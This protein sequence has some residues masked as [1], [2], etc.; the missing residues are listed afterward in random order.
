MADQ[1]HTAPNV[2]D[3]R[4]KTPTRTEGLRPGFAILRLGFAIVRLGLM[5]SAA[6][7]IARLA[8]AEIDFN[9][10]TISSVRQ[11]AQIGNSEYWMRLAELDPPHAPHFLREAALVDPRDAAAWIAL[12]LAEERV[13]EESAAENRKS[14]N[15]KSPKRTSPNDRSKSGDFAAAR[16]A[17]DKAFS[18][19]RQYSP[20]WAL[21]NF[22]LR[23]QDQGPDYDACFWRAAAR[24]ALRSPSLADLAIADSGGN[25]TGSSANLTD[26][27][28]LLDLAGRMEPSP[29]KTLDRLAASINQFAAADG[30][31]ATYA[32][33]IGRELE[34]AWL[35]DLIGQE[36]WEDAALI[37]QR[38]ESRHDAADK[39]RLDDLVDRL[40]AAGKAP[41]AVA[42]WNGYAA[43]TAASGNGTSAALAPFNGASLTNGDFA[44]EPTDMGFDW[45]LGLHPAGAFGSVLS[46][47]LGNDARQI[48]KRWQPNMLEFRLS[49]EEP[50]QIPMSEQWLPLAR[51]TYK[52][53]FEYSTRGLAAPT[54][55]RWDFVTRAGNEDKENQAAEKERRAGN[56]SLA[57]SE[58]WR[59]GE[60]IFSNTV[61]GVS[62]NTLPGVSSQR[63]AR[64]LTLGR[65][66]LIYSR[67]PGTERA[68]GLFSLRKVTLQT[69]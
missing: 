43:G 45:R 24:A 58:Q 64:P 55:I 49:G 9:G 12:G 59:A 63:G 68:R 21:A 31:T 34:R 38:I 14:Q 4:R 5:L 30:A 22:C 13:A 29:E 67:E 42:T 62:S 35:N 51:G 41:E 33:S 10:D 60:W 15:R 44:S 36:R 2:P 7:A 3:A 19:D 32:Q 23:H 47:A 27:A 52:L 37:A 48:A 11:A 56:D 61:S 53:R 69:L 8:N 28:P 17:F 54:G 26:L 25:R 66:R 20:A 1:D 6:F 65:L 50:E 39:A 18:L 57:P 46:G 40:I 16:A